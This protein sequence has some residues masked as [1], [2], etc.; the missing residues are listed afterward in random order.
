MAVERR[1]HKRVSASF[2]C[3]L[4]GA[5]RKEEPFDLLDLSESGVRMSCHHAIQPMTQIQVALKLPGERVGHKE[6]VRLETRGVV[7]WSHKESR[8]ASP[9]AAAGKSAA[10]KSSPAGRAKRAPAAGKA[11]AA[12]VANYDTGVFFPE[13]TRDQRA[14]IL[15][16][17]MSAIA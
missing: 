17:V 3:L 10:A 7:V 13:L 6:D 9:K 1:K 15:A 16:Y 12:P 2:P 5:D 8:S 14:L 4:V 11:E